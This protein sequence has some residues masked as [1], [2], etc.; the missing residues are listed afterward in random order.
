IAIGRRLHPSFL[1]HHRFRCAVEGPRR[2]QYPA[3]PEASKECLTMKRYMSLVVVPI[4]ALAACG[5]DN[6]GSSDSTS[7]TTAD[8]SHPDTS[9]GDTTPGDGAPGTSALTGV[10]T[11]VQVT[12]PTPNAGCDATKVDN[13]VNGAKYPWGGLTAGGV[14]YTCNSC[15]TGLKD[16]QGKWR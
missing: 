10:S 9:G 15:P 8:T 13:G 4:F 6:K 2:P 5:D 14:S 16:F 7:D 11:N 12:T 1:P 3:S